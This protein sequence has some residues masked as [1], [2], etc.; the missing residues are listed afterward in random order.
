MGAGSQEFG[1]GCVQSDL[2]VDTPVV[3]TSGSNI[4]ESGVW[5][6]IRQQIQT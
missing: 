2:L 4:L 3:K 1:L 6:E 5:G